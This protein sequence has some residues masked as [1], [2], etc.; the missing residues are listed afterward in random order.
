MRRKQYKACK[1]RLGDYEIGSG[2]A[3]NAVNESFGY[4]CEWVGSCL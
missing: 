2:K 3:E 4:L 1:T